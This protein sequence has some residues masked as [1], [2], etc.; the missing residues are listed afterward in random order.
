M[1][2]EST[3]PD[4]LVD[5]RRS[6]EAINRGDYDATLAR[7]APDAVLDLSPIGMD[8]VQ[9]SP[10]GHEA[11]RKL[12]EEVAATFSDFE[13][14]VEE[15][16]DLGNGV[17]LAVFSQRGKPRGSSARVEMR[18]AGVAQR[19]DELVER[20]TLYPDIDQARAAADQLVQQRR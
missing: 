3:T 2:K 17:T 11:I 10:R 16:L 15:L 8:L 4:L 12:W 19:K 20:L 14:D 5:L 13:I 18:Y 1:F 7:W 6:I 9:T